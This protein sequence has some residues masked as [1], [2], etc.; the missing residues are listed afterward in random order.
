MLVRG[1]RLG[2]QWPSSFTTCPTVSVGRLFEDLRRRYLLSLTA[3]T[4]TNLNYAIIP[5]LSNLEPA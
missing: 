3:K 2:R 4:L 5:E 1:G